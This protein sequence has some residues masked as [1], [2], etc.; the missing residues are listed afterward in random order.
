MYTHI[1]MCVYVHTDTYTK[2]KHHC[3]NFVLGEKTAN[4]SLDIIKYQQFVLV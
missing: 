4:H 2:M 3:R 1:Y